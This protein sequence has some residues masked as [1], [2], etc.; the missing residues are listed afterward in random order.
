MIWCGGGGQRDK[1][2]QTFNPG[3]PKCEKSSAVLPHADLARSFADGKY[4]IV[5]YI[6]SKGGKNIKQYAIYIAENEGEDEVLF[7]PGL[8]QFEVADAGFYGGDLDIVR[9]HEEGVE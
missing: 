6:Q 9:L 5:L 4:R 7:Q 2:G 3:Q 8:S 1:V